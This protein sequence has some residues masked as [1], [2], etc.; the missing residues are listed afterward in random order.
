MGFLFNFFVIIPLV[1][2]L[3]AVL[4]SVVEQ[5]QYVSLPKP[6]YLGSIRD[7]PPADSKEFGR[8]TKPLSTIDYSWVSSSKTFNFIALKHWDYKSVSSSRYFIVA[9]IA[10]LNYVANAFVYV[11]DRTDRQKAVYQYPGRSVLA[12]SIGE[13]AKSSIDGCTHFNQ[14]SSEFILLCYNPQAQRYEMKANVPVTGGLQVSFDL[15]IEYS[16][17][18]D[19]SMVLL[20]PVTNARPAYTH[21]VAALPAHGTLEISN[22]QKELIRDGLSSIDWTLAYSERLSRWKW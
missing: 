5:N 7:R 14:S 4:L 17:K 16:T 9:A 10:N 12:R 18:T 21:K 11:V 3:I 19:E 8:Y 13:Q 20:Y 6:D 15:Q 22:Q 1:V 2:A